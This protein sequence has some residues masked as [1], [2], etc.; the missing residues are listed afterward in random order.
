MLQALQSVPIHTDRSPF[1]KCRAPEDGTMRFGLFWPGTRTKLPSAQISALNPDNLDLGNHLSLIRACEDVGL[2]FVLLGD[3][4][5]PSSEEGTKIGFQ[6]PGIHAL[7]LTLPLILASRHIGIL[8]TL[9]STFF[10][11]AHI[12]RFAANLDWMS[13]GRWGWNIVNGY[14]DYEASLFG[15]EHLPDRASLYD[16]ASEAIEVIHS[17]WD[18]SR[19][20]EFDGAHYKSHGLLKGPY[21]TERPVYVCAAASPAGRKFTTRHCD[22]LFASPSDFSE[23]K[24]VRE[25][26]GQ[27][28][29]DLGKATPPRILVVA[30]LLIRDRP[31]E[32]SDLFNEMMATI[33]ANE[34]G[35]KWSG[36]IGRL[37]GQ[38]ANPFE[39][40]ALV[41][42]PAEVAEQLINAYRD[43][44]VNGVM[45]RPLIASA[46]EMLRLAPV[47]EKLEAEGVR[48]APAARNFC[49]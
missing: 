8:T 49:W 37:R 23:I 35:K 16:A 24:P 31:G 22:F 46:E 43:D 21:P 5:A 14:R 7:I 10:H 47:F 26:L 19:R 12:A 41:G 13:G 32:A 15:F 9:H 34:A 11:P 28:A 39:F 25:E 40:P 1:R 6:D 17:L 30:D 4:Y 45:F 27:H 36:Q 48:I 33:P 3:G 18:A 44:N 20:T 2:D 29:A 42:T 38:P